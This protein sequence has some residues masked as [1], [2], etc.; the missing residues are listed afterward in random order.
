MKPRGSVL[1]SHFANAVISIARTIMA[2]LAAA[3]DL[4][5]VDQ[6]DSLQARKW[7]RKAKHHW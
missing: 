4:A 3:F 6:N 5:Y 2:C 7:L 1:N